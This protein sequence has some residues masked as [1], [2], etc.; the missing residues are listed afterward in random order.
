MFSVNSPA[1]KCVPDYREPVSAAL[2]AEVIAAIG[3][4]NLE[5]Y[6]QYGRPRQVAFY[7]GG[8]RRRVR[9]IERR[10]AEAGIPARVLKNSHYM[11]FDILEEE[12]RWDCGL[13]GHQFMG[14]RDEHCQ[15]CGDWVGPVEV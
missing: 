2:A 15:F 12:V 6:G 10:L 8:N 11:G 4:D 13:G 5:W 3:R 7:P 1:I 9:A 14:P